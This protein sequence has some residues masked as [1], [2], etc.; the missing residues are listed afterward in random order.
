MGEASRWTQSMASAR[1]AQRAQHPYFTLPVIVSMLSNHYG[2]LTQGA[3]NW[4]VLVLLMLAGALI[5]HRSSPVTRPLS[6]AATP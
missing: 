2:W 6:Q 1:A 5:R 4:I 3:D